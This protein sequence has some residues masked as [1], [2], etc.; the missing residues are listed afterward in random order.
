MTKYY[1]IGTWY[2]K[3]PHQQFYNF[4]KGEKA[5]IRASLNKK[6]QHEI[7]NRQRFRGIF[8]TIE[9]GNIIYLKSFIIRGSKLRIRAIGKVPKNYK[10][11]INDGILCVKIEYHKNHDFDGI[12]EDLSI[13]DGI[14]RNERI[15]QETNS[16]VIKLI[17]KLLQK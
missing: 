14:K 13:N 12:T 4:I 1:G 2:K 3:K 5:C 15:Y 17:D 8:N 9:E 6:T 10:D 11:K 16:E 7:N